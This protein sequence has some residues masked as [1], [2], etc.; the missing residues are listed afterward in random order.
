MKSVYSIIQSVTQTGFK[1]VIYVPLPG[2]LGVVVVERPPRV[3]EVA[4]SIPGRVLPKALR[5][6]IMAT[7]L[8][9]QGCG[10]SITTDW[11]VSG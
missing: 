6:V 5:K 1:P 8:G 11:L 10:D 2:R 7:L 9:A 4:G 3:R